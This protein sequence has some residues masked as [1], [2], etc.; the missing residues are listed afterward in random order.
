VGGSQQ[1][2]FAYCQ[3]RGVVRIVGTPP[4]VLDQSD[5]GGLPVGVSP[6]ELGREAPPWT[7]VLQEMLR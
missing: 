4:A 3:R 5:P 6:K 7:S 1:L 2:V